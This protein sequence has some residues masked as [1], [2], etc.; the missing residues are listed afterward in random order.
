[1]RFMKRVPHTHGITS[2]TKKT[3]HLFYR[4][5]C[6][7]RIMVQITAPGFFTGRN[8]ADH[9]NQKVLKTSWVESGRVRRR[10]NSRSWGGSGRVGSG[11]VGSGRIGYGGFQIS[12]VG[13]GCF[14]FTR[15]DPREK[16]GIGSEWRPNSYLV[17]TLG[18]RQEKFSQLLS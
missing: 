13:T 12:R 15:P 8:P 7:K 3:V 1:M 6:K 16:P 4:S 11:R 17:A 9:S 18:V 14:T 2:L 10:L 5:R